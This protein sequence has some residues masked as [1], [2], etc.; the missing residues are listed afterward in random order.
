MQSER[1]LIQVLFESLCAS[2]ADSAVARAALV[3]LLTRLTK[4]Q[5]DEVL[6]TRS[7]KPVL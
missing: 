5:F 2:A 7:E 4:E 6:R 1:E 3:E